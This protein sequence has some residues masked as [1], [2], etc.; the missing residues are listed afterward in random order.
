MSGWLAWNDVLPEP[1]LSLGSQARPAWCRH[2]QPD[3]AAFRVSHRPIPHTCSER[4]TKSQLNLPRCCCAG[5][6]AKRVSVEG[7]VRVAEAH[8][9]WQIVELRPELQYLRFMDVDV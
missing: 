9:V 1:D 7:R 5:D 4:V 8:T 6:L 2:S 3:V